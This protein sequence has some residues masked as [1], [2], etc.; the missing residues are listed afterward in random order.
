[1]LLYFWIWKHINGYLFVFVFTAR[2]FL[3]SSWAFFHNPFLSHPLI[4]ANFSPSMNSWSLFQSSILAYAQS[5]LLWETERSHGRETFSKIHSKF[6][7]PLLL[8]LKF[9]LI[10]TYLIDMIKFRANQSNFTYWNI[11]IFLL[12]KSFHIFA[13][14]SPSILW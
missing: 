1:M 5:M 3:S 13:V 8:I 14:Y 2:I 9:R 6:L 10:E 4:I 12:F 7:Y 11:F